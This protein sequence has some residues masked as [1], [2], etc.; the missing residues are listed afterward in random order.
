MPVLEG[1]PTELMVRCPLCGAADL[2]PLIRVKEWEIVECR[3]CLLGMLASPPDEAELSRLYS[4]QY[5]ADHAIGYTQVEEARHRGVR[6]Q[7][8]RAEM[9][10]RW[11]RGGRLLDVGCASGYFLAA[12][13]ACGFEAEGVELSTWA[14]EEA[15][16][17]FG[18][19][20]T[21]GESDILGRE[22][23]FDAITMWHSLE[24]TRDPL[25]TV[26]AA[27]ALLRPGGVLAI[28]LPNHR[29]L[30]AE[31]Y[32]EAWTGWSV[33]YHLWHF[34]PQSLSVLLDRGGFELKAMKTSPSQYVRER[35]KRVPVLGLLRKPIAA[36][37]TGRDVT[38]VAVRG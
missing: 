21:I 19:R 29:S 22:P 25:A 31:K 4:E 6:G 17:H 35:L 16:K 10:K 23:R 38:A 1:E 11:K 20:V 9:V 30:D 7:H 5:F 2:A 8:K 28:E 34:S 24:H 27:R 36:C 26:R 32:G 18:V 33:P 37:F 3:R 12:A 14:A 13:R 15:R